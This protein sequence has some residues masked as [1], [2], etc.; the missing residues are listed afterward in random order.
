MVKDACW[1]V[2]Q[3]SAQPLVVEGLSV[4]LPS[5]SATGTSMATFFKMAKTVLYFC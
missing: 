4:P 5:V 1:R 3:A 2:A